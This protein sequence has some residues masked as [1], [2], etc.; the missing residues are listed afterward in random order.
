MKILKM[1]GG[2]YLP[3]RTQFRNKALKVKVLNYL[4]QNAIY[5]INIENL[6]YELYNEFISITT[7]PKLIE[8]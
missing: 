5:D 2:V 4:I 1:T 6:N 7:D 8:N 3:P